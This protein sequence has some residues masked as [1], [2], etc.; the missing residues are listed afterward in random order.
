MQT[1]QAYER[2]GRLEALD[3]LR[4][5]AI[6][7]VLCCHAVMDAAACNRQPRFGP[8]PAALCVPASFSGTTGVMLFFALSGF[9]LFLPYARALLAPEREHTSRSWPSA[10]GFYLRR[11]RRILPAYYPLYAMAIVVPWLIAAHQLGLS[12]AHLPWGNVIGGG[13]LIYDLGRGLFNAVTGPDLPLWSLTVEWQFYLVLP[14]LA[15]GLRR[16]AGRGSVRTRTCRLLLGLGAVVAVGLAAR[17]VTAWAHYGLGYDD[18]AGGAPGAAGVVFA[19]LYGI[20]GK[21]LEVFAMGMLASVLYVTYLVQPRARAGA[22]GAVRRSR[23]ARWL[24]LLAVLGIVGCCVWALASGAFADSQAWYWPHGA[25]A[26]AWSAWT[27]AIFGQWAIGVCGAVLL[28]LA[29]LP[30]RAWSW[31]A[32]CR[33]S[34]LR[35]VGIISYS[36]YLW[37]FPFLL[38][39]VGLVPVPPLEAA[40]HILVGV[41]FTVV[42]A[43]ANYRLIERPFLVRRAKPAVAVPASVPSSMPALAPAAEHR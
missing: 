36:L 23:L 3:G 12:P 27:W 13:V 40:R 7:L 43:Y 19:L 15:L 39:F 34:L 21:Y 17:G 25:D 2:R 16:L 41:T 18:P 30:A 5:L 24:P 26:G 14:L 29:L 8:P 6:L 10:W 32:L 22:V 33:L 20:K 28:L 31:G 9:L 37:Q 38:V 42:F 4:G 35:G 1:V 11:M